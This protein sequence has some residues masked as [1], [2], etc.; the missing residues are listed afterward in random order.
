MTIV[1]TGAA[2]H[3]GN[4]LVRAL[5][6][7]GQRPRVLLHRDRNE[8]DRLGVEI[9]EGDVLEPDSLF[10]AFEGA[11]VVYHVAGR[12]S[13]ST[14]DWAETEALNIV[15]TRNVVEACLRCGVRRMVH[16]SSIHALKDHAYHGMV[17]ESRPLVD[18]RRAGPYAFT[19]A[20]GE[21]EVQGGIERGLDA[22]ILR[23]TAAIG[24]YDYRPSHFGEALV[25]I[26]KGKWPALVTGGFDW[27]DARDVAEGA[28]LAATRGSAGGRYIISG[29]W[30]SV[31]ELG[32][33]IAELRGIRAPSVIF[34]LWVAGIAA[35]LAPPFY[36]LLGQ[37]AIFTSVTVDALRSHRN[38]SGALAARELGYE[39]RPFRQTI[40]DTLAWFE[41][42]GYL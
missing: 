6:A 17:D 22:V 15:G 13:V 24:P 19:K 37:R 33:T 40:A 23:P 29:H 20:R 36:R 42:N 32:R 27:V 38:I 10:R 12:V 39:P 1:I 9:A 35:P 41:D 21:K 7:R 25:A 16:F 30:V 18:T 11:D 8:F 26:A 34:P 3:L 5:L 31:A 28:I 2:G 14:S 4:N